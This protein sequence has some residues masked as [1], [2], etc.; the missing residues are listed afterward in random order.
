[1]NKYNFCSK[2]ITEPVVGVDIHFS[3]FLLQSIR[4]P[5]SIVLGVPR[6][7]EETGN[8]LEIFCLYKIQGETDDVIVLVLTRAI[9][10]YN[11]QFFTGCTFL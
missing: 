6:N 8:F 2:I 10:H 1:M 3:I 4:P 11:C 9:I 7:I 5:I